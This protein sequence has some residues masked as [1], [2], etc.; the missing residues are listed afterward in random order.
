MNSLLDWVNCKSIYVVVYMHRCVLFRSCARP[1][2]ISTHIAIDM[3]IARW[4]PTVAMRYIV[5]FIEMQTIYASNAFAAICI[6]I[7]HLWN[8]RIMA[9][10]KKGEN[11]FGQF[12]ML[13]I[14]HKYVHVHGSVRWTGITLMEITLGSVRARTGSKRSFLSALLDG[15]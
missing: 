4:R 6:C 9:T 3:W 2:E 10:R 13:E 14:L 5:Q 11:V 15:K 7:T 8:K 1:S 12:V